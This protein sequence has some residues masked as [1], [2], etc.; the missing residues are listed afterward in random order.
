MLSCAKF[1]RLGTVAFLGFALSNPA[2]AEIDKLATYAQMKAIAQQIQAIR[3][4]ANEQAT[5]EQLQAQYDALMA[6]MGGDDPTKMHESAAPANG[7][8]IVPQISPLAIVP[9]PPAG[10]VVTTTSFTNST[11]TAIP[12]GPAVV[13]STILVSGAG[14]YLWDVD[15][16]TFLQHTF[17]ADLD[18]TIQSPSG[19]V[20]TLTT[21]NGAGNDNVFNGTVWDDQAGDPVSD[22][23]YTNLTT[24]THLSPEEALGAFRGENP[25]GTWTITIS[26]D[27]AGDGG[28]LDSWSLDVHTLPST[29]IETTS[30]FSN[31]TATPILD[32]ATVTSDI[33]V[34]GMGTTLTSV[35]L[36]TFITHTFSADLDIT[37]KSPAGTVIKLT[38]D[39]GAGNDD[40]FN[41]TN[42]ND[43]ANPAGQVPYTTNSGLVTDNPYVNLVTAASLVPEQPLSAFLGENPNGT[44]TLS[45]ADDL[46]GD[47]GTLN[48]WTL[49]IT[50]GIGLAAPVFA[51]SPAPSG[52]VPFT[53]GTVIGSTGNASITVSVAT[54]GGGTGASATTTTTCSAP[55]APFNGFAQ[56]VSAEGATAIGG[57][58]LAGSCVLGAAVATQTLTCS[59]NQ[60][61][62]PVVRTFNLSCPAG[63]VAP[64]V[65][66][67]SPAPSGTV[68]F[69]GGTAVGST[70]NAS[71]TVS[72]ATPG[73]GT[74]AGATT[75]TTCSAPSAPFS[76]F[77]QVVSAV[78][79]A[80]TSGGP[81]AGSCVLGAAVAT[82]TLTC[83]ENQGGTPVIR[84]FNLSCPAGTVVPLTSTPT[85]G[86]SITLPSKFLDAAPT[87]AAITFSN[88][89]LVGATVTCVAPTATQFTVSP[90]IIPIPAG[91]TAGTTIS[92]NSTTSG[93][94]HGVLNC[95]AGSQNFSFNLDGTAGEPFAVPLFGDT[96]LQW[97]VLASLLIG[98]VAFG[99]HT[100]RS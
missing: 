82:Q 34:S 8:Q 72:V 46:A 25:N 20:V 83:S 31:N 15:L 33:V 100:R 51:Y 60:G 19:T 12:T 64:P 52:T 66:A 42:W 57:G 62:T 49:N 58:P 78:G 53:G 95:S 36:T 75:T 99:Q 50:T 21:D 56:V 37:L 96:L 98:M 30:P 17:A 61:G 93:P 39:N 89:G 29:P 13:T 22:H 79:A 38:T 68:P 69:A 85:S 32:V 44:W 23:V 18:I 65:F 90:L 10:F 47:T 74:G 35:D 9:P 63:T 24:A 80:S 54:P 81:L 11:P 3:G 97:L 16:T 27:L 73:V 6:S 26:D 4:Q 48:N 7:G 94:F 87:T 84:T 70:G 28:S 5:L 40:V 91:G 2:S 1:W 45:I 92:F 86:N 77:A 43:K 59:E 76:G 14:P 88:P 55:S 71:I 41:G 67:Y